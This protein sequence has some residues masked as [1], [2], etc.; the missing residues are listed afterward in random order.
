MNIFKGTLNSMTTIDL[1]R[2]LQAWGGGNSPFNSLISTGIPTRVG[3]SP[4]K[5]T[6]KVTKAL[7]TSGYLENFQLKLINDEK[8]Q[9]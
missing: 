8:E 3:K 2:A 4:L 1:K 9:N 6:R 7:Y 5:W